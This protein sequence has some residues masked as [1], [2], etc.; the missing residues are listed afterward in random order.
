MRALEGAWRAF[1]AN[2]DDLDVERAFA[3]RFGCAPRRIVVSHGLKLAGPIEES[4]ETTKSAVSA[5][6]DVFA[7]L[8]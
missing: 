3:E 2:T 5:G 6:D 1:S 8:P 4:D 7:R